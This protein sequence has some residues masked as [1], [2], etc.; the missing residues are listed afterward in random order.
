MTMAELSSCRECRYFQHDRDP[1]TGARGWCKRRAPLP[2]YVDGDDFVR[3]VLA[4]WPIVDS[5]DW[6]G[7]FERHN[8]GDWPCT[9]HARVNCQECH[10]QRSTGPACPNCKST[11]VEDT[12]QGVT[13]LMAPIPVQDSAGKWTMRDPNTVRR[14]MLCRDCGSQFEKT[15]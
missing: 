12:G 8:E 5:D 1:G 3:E 13:T 6:C 10:V 4:L 7:E 14:W 15:P 2:H 11:D 9:K